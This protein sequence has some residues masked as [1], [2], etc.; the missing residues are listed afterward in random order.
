MAP[1]RRRKA[2]KAES[3]A[4]LNFTLKDMNGASVRLADYKGKVI[5]AQLLGDVVRAVQGG[6]SRRSS[7]STTSYKDQGLV[8]LGVLRRRRCRKR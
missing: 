7:S 2:C 4:N 3:Q 8:I 1:V 5:A 6:D